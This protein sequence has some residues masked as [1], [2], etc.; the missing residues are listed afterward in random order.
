[1][2]LM[3][4]DL[5]NAFFFKLKKLGKIMGGG[6]IVMGAKICFCKVSFIFLFYFLIVSSMGLG[7]LNPTLRLRCLDVTSFCMR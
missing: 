5:K 2:G 4:G 3:I 1:M 7:F 6:A